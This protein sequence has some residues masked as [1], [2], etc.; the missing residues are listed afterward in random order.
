MAY[1]RVSLMRPMAGHEAEVE[2]LNR[3]LVAYYRR[4]PGCLAAYFVQAAD[5]SGELGRVSVWE[6]EEDADRAANDDHSLALRSRLHL[7]IQP[8][9]QDR[10]FQAQAP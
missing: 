7:L 2:S 10:S 1:I 4:F 3:E 6:R 9:H 5:G 8:G